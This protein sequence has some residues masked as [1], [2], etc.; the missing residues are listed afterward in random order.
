M[1]ERLLEAEGRHVGKGELAQV[2]Q[3]LGHQEGDDR[4]ADQEA[5][6]V[7]QAIKAAGHHGRGDAQEG[8][9]RHV[10]AGDGEA[11]LEAG[12]AA[13][14]GVEVGCGLGLGGRPLGDE[15]REHH[16]GAEHAD[17]GPVG[18]LLLGLA[19]IGAGGVHDG[20]YAKECDQRQ[21]AAHVVGDSFH[22]STAL[23]IA[24][25]SS[26]NSVLARRT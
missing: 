17:R 2:A 18:G 1:A 25:D 19:Q 21:C 13:A 24:S 22:L 4:P 12:D 5:D 8:R 23:E 6:R 9:R 14:C 7:D 16:E 10:V 26:S 15:Q 20:R 11:V 3:A